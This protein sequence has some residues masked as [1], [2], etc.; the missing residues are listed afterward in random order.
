[1]KPYPFINLDHVT[2]RRVAGKRRPFSQAIQ[3]A[4]TQ[5]TYSKLLTLPLISIAFSSGLLTSTNFNLYSAAVCLSN[6]KMSLP[7]LLDFVQNAIQDSI[8]ASHRRF[9]SDDCVKSLSYF[10]CDDP[11]A[12]TGANFNGLQG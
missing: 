7:E 12:T 10:G 5:L 4:R 2:R 3:S 9:Y 6:G 8:N 11:I 1:M